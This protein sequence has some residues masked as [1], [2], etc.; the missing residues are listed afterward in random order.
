MTSLLVT[1]GPFLHAAAMIVLLIAS[2]RKFR[3]TSNLPFIS[4]AVFAG[5]AL[6]ISIAKHVV[7]NLREADS[8]IPASVLAINWWGGHLL[9]VLLGVSGLLMLTEKVSPRGREEAAQ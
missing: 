3:Q 9:A 7:L 8:G 6:G 5:S 2:I 4:L 1:L